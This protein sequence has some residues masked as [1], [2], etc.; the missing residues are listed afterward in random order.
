MTISF[1]QV[2]VSFTLAELILQQHHK[3]VTFNIKKTFHENYAIFGEPVFKKYYV[4]FDY[5]RDRIGL[6]PPR[7]TE[8]K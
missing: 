3:K 7:V 8:H 4:A 2:K 1:N 6:G 5:G